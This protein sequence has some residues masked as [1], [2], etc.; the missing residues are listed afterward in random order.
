MSTKTDS[1][2]RVQVDVSHCPSPHPFSNKMGRVLWRTVWLLFF[3]PS[4]RVLHGWR[5]VLLRLFGARLGYK[6]RVYPSAIIWAPW[7]LEMGEHSCL[8]DYVDCYSVDRITLGPHATVSQYSYLCS[9]GHDYTDPRMPLTTAPITIAQGAWVA[10]DV[11]IGP[12]VTV[13]DG[14]VVGAR[15]SVFKNVAPWTVVAG[16]PVRVIKQRTV[17]ARTVSPQKHS[18]R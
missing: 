7:N 4:P 12:G 14:A 9:A 18:A 17:E 8:G 16:N 11:F 13:G 15:S 3:R 5:R 6:A 10:A 1:D 2:S